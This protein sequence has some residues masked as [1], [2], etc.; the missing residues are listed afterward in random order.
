MEIKLEMT[1]ESILSFTS[2]SIAHPVL[3]VDMARIFLHELSTC[4]VHIAVKTDR[5]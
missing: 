3:F 1:C 5:A 4:C 2:S